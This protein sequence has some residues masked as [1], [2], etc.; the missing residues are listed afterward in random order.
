[1][2]ER[3]IFSFH[4]VRVFLSPTC[5]IVLAPKC[6]ALLPPLLL[7]RAWWKFVRDENRSRSGNS[8]LQMI[9]ETVIDE[10]CYTFWHRSAFCWQRDG[11]R[12]SKVFAM[13][14]HHFRFDV[15]RRWRRV[16]VGVFL[17]LFRH[18]AC[19]ESPPTPD[20]TTRHASCST[21]DI[22]CIAKLSF[23]ASIWLKCQTWT[24]ST[25]CSLNTARRFNLISDYCSPSSCHKKQNKS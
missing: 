7:H 19:R 18:I 25:S 15:V 1:M 2:C 6:A 23:T 10:I 24:P 11:R 14:A 3:L 17:T 8:G 20:V 9:V 13:P 22:E 12:K 4:S 16:S 21:F 5:A